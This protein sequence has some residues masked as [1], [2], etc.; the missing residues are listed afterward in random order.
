MLKNS[1]VVA[2]LTL[3]KGCEGEKIFVFMIKKSIFDKDKGC[4]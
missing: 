4:D 3:K 2:F 1:A